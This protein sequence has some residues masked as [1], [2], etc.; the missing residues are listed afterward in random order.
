MSID[1]VTGATGL[2]GGNLVRALVARGR[3]VRVLVRSH[4]RTFHLAGLPGLERVQGD[5]TDLP[6]L[7]SSF[8]GVEN[9]YHCAAM[10][11]M[12]AGHAAQMWRVNVTG[13]QNVIQAVRESWVRRL[14]Y[15][16]SVD[17]IGLPEAGYTSAEATPWN[18]DR[19]GLDVP[20][21]RTKYEAQKRVLWAAEAGLDAVVVNPTFMF[22]AYDPRPSSGRLILEIAGGRVR[23]YPVGGNNFVD[24]EDVVEAMISAAERGK[25]GECYILG[26]QNLTY[27]EIFTRISKI[28]RSSPPRLAIPYPLAR[29]GGWLGDVWG[30]I[31]RREPPMNTA[32]AKLGYV[33]HYYSAKKAVRE[34]GLRQTPIEE[35]IERAVRWFC[36]VGMMPAV[37]RTS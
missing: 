23:G 15:C 36:D 21:A 33:D 30:W 14:V 26:N 6:S 11:S 34:L 18:W 9:V 5:I 8:R 17:A 2:V 24:V 7:R 4:S 31:I 28:V 22:G 13:T 16:S 19:V 1:L 3:R 27:R 10:V 37:A 32:T 29:V 12:W 20:Y 25:R 35:A